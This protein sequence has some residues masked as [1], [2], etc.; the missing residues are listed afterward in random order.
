MQAP[1]WKE[2]NSKHLH[3]NPK[4]DPYKSG[5]LWQIVLHVLKSE[6]KNLLSHPSYLNHL[7]TWAIR[8][9]SWSKESHRNLTH[10]VPSGGAIHTKD[11]WCWGR[12]LRWECTTEHIKF[13]PTI[14]GLCGMRD[15]SSDCASVEMVYRPV[16]SRPSKLT[17]DV[18]V[19]A[20]KL[21]KC[22]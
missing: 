15:V 19:T 6:A 16:S 5:P 7:L 22:G 8:L 4:T 20:W 11:S 3:K 12:G 1:P 2:Q 14:P 17:L 21:T 10:P 18:K 9:Y 13:C